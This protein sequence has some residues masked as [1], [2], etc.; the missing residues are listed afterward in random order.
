MRRA[1]ELAPWRVPLGDDKTVS[2]SLQEPVM[3]Y[4]LDGEQ[5]QVSDDTSMMN[6]LATLSDK[7]MPNIIS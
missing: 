6:A 3:E 2:N 4:H 7:A 1:A 5:F